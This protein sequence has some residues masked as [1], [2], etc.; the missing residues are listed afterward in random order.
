MSRFLTF[1][2]ALAVLVA[3]FGLLSR[4]WFEVASGYLASDV[5]IFQ[6]VGRGILNGLTPYVDLFE[7]KPPGIFLLHALSWKLFDSQLLVKIAQAIAL[8]GIPVLVTVPAINLIQDRPAP[9]RRILSLLS[10]VFGLLLAL[11][12]ADQA[13]LGLVES[14]GAVFAIW[15]LVIFMG[16]HPSIG[17]LRGWKR[18]VVLGLLLLC[19]VGLKEPFLLSILGGLILLD[20]PRVFEY[21]SI[22]VLGV[23]V[24]ISAAIGIAALLLFGYFDAFFTVYLPHMLGYHVHQHDG[25]TFVRALELWRTFANMG[26]YS[27]WFAI[28]VTAVWIY[29][30][31]QSLA[32]GY[33]LLAIRWFASSYLALLSIA[34]GGDFYGHHF[35]F[36]LP[37]FVAVFWSVLR[38]LSERSYRIALPVIATFFV[39]AGI[40]DTQF[41]YAAEAKTWRSQ[42][43]EFLSVA[44]TIDTVME[45]CNWDRYL[46]MVP[47]GGGPYAYTKASPYGPVF[48]HYERFLGAA[49]EYQSAYIKALKETP[50]MLLI[51]LERSNLSDFAQRY[52]GVHF[53]EEPPKCVGQDFSQPEPYT[54]LFQQEK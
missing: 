54:L 39:V 50:F 26:A 44:A 18:M 8:L 51:D 27:W 48:I 23:S 7:T 21:S 34:V 41:S 24:I 49:K 33:W 20:Q 28:G 4:A 22:R 1:A 5:L 3:L 43:S 16:S 6:T 11:Y 15:Y 37:F 2:L 9:Q 47:R 38:M 35:I 29:V 31:I 52:V 12:A 19:A 42:E 17:A 30:P 10:I 25:S 32:T 14:L 13:G 40:I 46:Q 53:S 45:R 36:A